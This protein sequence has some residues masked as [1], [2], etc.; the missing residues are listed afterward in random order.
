MYA[1]VLF[2]NEQHCY[3]HVR[4]TSRVG[5]RNTYASGLAVA[6]VCLCNAR[7]SRGRSVGAVNGRATFEGRTSDGEY[8]RHETT[9]KWIPVSSFSLVTFDKFL[10]RVLR[11][12]N[13]SSRS[14]FR[15][16]ALRIRGLSLQVRARRRGHGRD[17]ARGFCL[18]D[19]A[20]TRTHTHTHADRHC[21]ARSLCAIRRAFVHLCV[22]VPLCANIR[23]YTTRL[24][25]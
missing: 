23:P 17:T 6:R 9:R 8:R 3:E 15:R 5:Q 11:A 7:S 21:A 1:R 4:Q 14:L 18:R 16:L 24:R 2:P 12:A 19:R 25:F 20:S 10:E 22:F 13:I